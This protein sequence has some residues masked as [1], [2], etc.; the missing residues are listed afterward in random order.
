MFLCCQINNIPLFISTTHAS[1]YV[2]VT[3]TIPIT[4]TQ[5]E[6][7]PFINQRFIYHRIIHPASDSLCFS[8]NDCDGK[9]FV[10]KDIACPSRSRKYDFAAASV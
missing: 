6:L 4:L 1:G 10:G 3:F 7:A 2:M 9:N 5:W 8:S